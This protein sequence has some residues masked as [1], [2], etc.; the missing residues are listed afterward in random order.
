MLKPQQVIEAIYEAT[1][2]EA[3]VTT[4]VGQHQMWA[5]QYYRCRR[6]RQFISSGGLGAMGF[7]F[8]AAIGAQFARPDALVV[9]IVGDGGFQMTMQDLITAVE[10]QLPLKIYVINNASLGMVRQWQQLFYRERYY[11][12][13]LRNPDFARIAEA[14]GAVGFRVTNEEQMHDAIVR[15]L[16]ICDRPVVVDFL[17][18]PEENCYPMIPSGQSVKEMIVGD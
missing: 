12:V 11:A 6:P 13:H 10:W 9:A 8:P 1:R 15:S 5:A 18:D 7:G 17:V 2:G 16:Q 14:F 3:I 4:D